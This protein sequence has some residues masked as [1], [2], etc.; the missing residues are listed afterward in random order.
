MIWLDWLIWSWSWLRRMGKLAILSV[1]TISLL[2]IWTYFLWLLLLK[3]LLILLRLLW[4]YMLKRARIFVA[5]SCILISKTYFLFL[6]LIILL[7]L[8]L[9]LMRKMT[10]ISITCTSIFHIITNIIVHS[11][12]L[13]P[14][15]FNSVKRWKKKKKK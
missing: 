14:L 7:C 15:S 4:L 11:Y 1:F 13:L 6:L 5:L 8:R 12:W 3:W 9:H 2:K 10:V